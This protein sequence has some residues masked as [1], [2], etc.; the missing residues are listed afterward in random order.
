LFHEDRIACLQAD[1]GSKESLEAAVYGLG[2]FDLIVDDGSHVPKHQVLTAHTLIPYLAHKG[3]YVLEDIW[4]DC[5]PHV[6]MDQMPDISW[7]VVPVGVG[8]G[9]AAHCECEF[10]GHPEVLLVHRR[11]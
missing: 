5:R 7:D 2:K 9:R 1:Q 8:W 4:P 11:E 6:L 10:G 3:V